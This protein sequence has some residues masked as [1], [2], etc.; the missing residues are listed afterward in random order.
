MLPTHTPNTSDL[1][2]AALY[3]A[4]TAASQ[5]MPLSGIQHGAMVSA[6]ADAF[7]DGERDFVRLQQRAIDVL[8]PPTPVTAVERRKRMRLVHSVAELSCATRPD[9]GFSAPMRLCS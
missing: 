8:N 2:S 3:T 7:A 9:A 1:M 5:V 6:I 4:W